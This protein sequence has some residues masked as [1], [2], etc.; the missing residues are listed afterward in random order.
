MK[1]LES[2]AFGAIILN[3]IMNQP[4]SKLVT[5]DVITP[6]ASFKE[7]FKFAKHGE[8]LVIPALN[9]YDVLGEITDI[10]LTVTAPN[11]TKLI[12]NVTSQNGASILVDQYG[13]YKVEYVVF[14][15]AGTRTTFSREFTVYDRIRPVITLSGAVPEKV[16]VGE[17]LR[18]PQASAYDNNKLDVVCK[19][20]VTDPNGI[21]TLVEA[22][23]TYKVNKAGRYT[24]VYYAIDDDGACDMHRF[25]FVAENK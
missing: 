13:T 15:D 3:S 6:N 20:Y 2:D 17:N 4:F 25:T 16:K 8:T 12:N 18:L 24:V 14:D 9:A 22:N 1:G 23:Q 21:I 11:G 10:K 5:N 7:E 19:V